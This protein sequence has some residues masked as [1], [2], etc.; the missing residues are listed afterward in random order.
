[1]TDHAR[2][3]LIVAAAVGLG[4]A[5]S[6]GGA[7]AAD[8]SPSTTAPTTTPTT[9]SPTATS[10]PTSLGSLVV[11]QPLPGL[12]AAPA[13]P[14]N[15]PL[16]VSE[17][18]SQSSEPAQAEQQFNA[19]A[20]KQGFGAFIRLWTDRGGAGAGAN[21]LAVLLFRISDVAAAQA[22]A[23]GL[24]QPFEQASGS[25]P[26]AVP[27]VPGAQGYSVSVHSPVPAIERVVVFRA[28]RYV[29][30]VELAS[31]SA[32]T[33]P[34][35]LTPA[36]AVAASYLQ[37]TQVRAGDP[38]NSTTVTTP[39]PRAPT[40]PGTASSNR[41]VPSGSGLTVALV[42]VVIL[43]ALVVGLVIWRRRTPSVPAPARGRAT[44]LDP[45]GPGGAFADFAEVGL[46][47]E[48]PADPDHSA[49]APAAPDLVA[50]LGT[51]LG[52]PCAAPASPAQSPSP[53]PAPLAVPALV[54]SDAGSSIG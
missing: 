16:T 30:M 9:A 49:P 37:L 15:G 29:T 25:T 1:M 6:G 33:N 27:S 14:T 8:S 31:T 23:S 36:Q 40:P 3:A 39:P 4:T 50:A 48:E 13:G 35:P 38:V 51:L 24:N 32:A 34:A 53:A 21:D 18:A 17:F 45:W 7:S 12:T 20:A 5:L 47:S 46:A 41:L 26:F 2:R 10:V 42:A 22:F 43:A 44:V 19:L 54:R 52:P 11:T 28:G